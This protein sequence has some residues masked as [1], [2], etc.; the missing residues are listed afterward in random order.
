MQHF[1]LAVE[2]ADFRHVAQLNELIK[3]QI[4]GLREL[5]DDFE[6]FFRKGEYRFCDEPKGRE[7]TAWIRA[8]SRLIGQVDLGE[9]GEIVEG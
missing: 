9:T 1:F 3:K 5:K 8:M 4:R 7:Q 2:D 6:E